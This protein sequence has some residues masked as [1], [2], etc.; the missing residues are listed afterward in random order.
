VRSMARPLAR[1][2]STSPGR[3]PATPAT[4]SCPTRRLRR[5]ASERRGRIRPCRPP[6][7][8]PEPRRRR[9]RRQHHSVPRR[10]RSTGGRRGRPSGC[11]TEL[12][13]A[14]ALI[15]RGAA[16]SPTSPTRAPSCSSRV[17]RG[18][19]LV[20]IDTLVVVHSAHQA[21]AAKARSEVPRVESDDD[22]RC[23]CIGRGAPMCRRRCG[24]C[25]PRAGRAQGRSGRSLPLRRS[26]T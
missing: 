20:V 25:T 1:A 10:I 15:S 14:R 5:P 13:G 17:G 26:S 19:P 24:R 22:D 16:V 9:K 7:L 12:V 4:P 8:D 23:R 18:F 6:R 11:L 2:N 3:S 21:T